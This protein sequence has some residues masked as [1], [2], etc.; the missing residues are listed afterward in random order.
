MEEKINEL[1]NQMNTL[2]EKISNIENNAVSKSELS[3]EMKPLANEIS[4]IKKEMIS[5]NDIKIKLRTITGKDI[6]IY[7]KRS[8]KIYDLKSKIREKENISE[9]QQS[10]FLD[11]K[12]LND[13]STLSDNNIKES[14]NRFLMKSDDEIFNF[15]SA[16]EKIFIINSI[17][18]ILNKGINVL[19]YSAR[20][21]GDDA[22]TFHKKVD[23]NKDLLYLIKTTN[24]ISFAI[25]I[26]KPLLSDGN[27]RTDSLQ[28][29]ISPAHK[30]AIKSLNNNA[31][32]HCRSDKGAQFHC[33]ELN[34]PFLSS[35]C[36]D[37]NSC[38]DFNLPAYPTGNSSYNI[39][40]LEVYSLRDLTY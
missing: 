17:K 31:T 34:T 35:N 12:L 36:V 25:Y 18:K 14:S 28:M 37:I 29:V 38:N 1:V 6:E 32:Y 40:E 16:E 8:D 22:S 33:M 15:A 4:A 30:F 20:K 9:G 19:L 3:N 27:S 10:I 7:T 21:D 11:D 5:K 23:K 13:N 39:K 2:V 26:D 24:D